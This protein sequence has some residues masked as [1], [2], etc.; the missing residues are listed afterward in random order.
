MNELSNTEEEAPAD[1]VMKAVK[2]LVNLDHIDEPAEKE[3]KLSMKKQEEEKARKVK[4][5]KSRGLPPVAKNIV[6]SQASLAQISEVKKVHASSSG[7]NKEIM[8][9]PPQP[10]HP[11]AAAAGMLVIHG[12]PQMG[13]GAPPL[14]PQGFG[15]AYRQAQYM[16]QG[17]PPQQQQQ[18][19][20]R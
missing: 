9:A 17:Y 13:G 3:Y 4:D 15:V 5:G 7:T 2:N 14:Q 12:A 19:Q 11:E 16:Q 8:K 6:G 1:P 20:Y 10:W 18:Y